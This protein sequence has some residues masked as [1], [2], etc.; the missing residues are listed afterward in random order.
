MKFDFSQPIKL[1][2]ERVILRPLEQNDFTYLLPFS[3][4]EKDLWDF[5]LTPAAGAENLQTYIDSALTAKINCMHT[6][7]WF[8]INKFMKLRIVLVFMIFKLRIMY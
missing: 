8:S 2:N 7:L 4:N 1:E 5:S 3:E 6:P